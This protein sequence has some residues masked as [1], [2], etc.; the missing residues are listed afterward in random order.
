MEANACVELFL[1]TTEEK[2]CSLTC[3]DIYDKM[4]EERFEWLSH[5]R[6]E[7]FNAPTVADF[8]LR[9]KQKRLRHRP[10][11]ASRL[12]VSASVMAPDE[13]THSAKMEA[14]TMEEGSISAHVHQ[15]P[16]LPPPAPT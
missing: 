15:Q 2:R 4:A 16:P 11:A 13:G 12:G 9:G 7:L 8:C 10:P 1:D 14:G 6:P 3:G 5:T